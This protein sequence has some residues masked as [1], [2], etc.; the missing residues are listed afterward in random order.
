MSMGAV[1]WYQIENWIITWAPII[2]M[3]LLV[4]FLWRTMKLM[5]RTKPQEIT[6]DSASAVQWSQVA[7]AD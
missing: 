6:P 7:G 2:F 5:P 4:F 3:A 1:A